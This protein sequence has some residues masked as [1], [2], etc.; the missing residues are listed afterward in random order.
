MVWVFIS[1]YL[2]NPEKLRTGLERMMEE[3]RK[4]LRGNPE[5]EAKAWLDKLAEADRMRTGYQE[6]AAKGLMTFEELGARLKDL[7][8]TRRLAQ[9]ELELLEGR[10]AELRHLERDVDALLETYAET[11]PGKLDDLTPEQRH[12]AYKML[13]L[14]CVLRTEGP[15]ELSGVFVA[16]TPN[17]REKESEYW[18][19]S[20]KTLGKPSRFPPDRPSPPRPPSGAAWPVPGP[21]GGRPTDS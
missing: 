1:D 8:D 9:R 21:G 18:S 11:V 4:D 12:H 6:L 10:R 13:G 3:K 2:K 16:N 5:Q 19:P 7:E 15:P 14:G 20:A 17:V